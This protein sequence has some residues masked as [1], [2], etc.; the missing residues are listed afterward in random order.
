[1]HTIQQGQNDPRRETTM[2]LI[3][4]GNTE[5]VAMCGGNWVSFFKNKKQM[6]TPVVQDMCLYQFKLPISACAHQFLSNHFM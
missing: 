3:L 2:A 5:R 1:M 4:D 6:F